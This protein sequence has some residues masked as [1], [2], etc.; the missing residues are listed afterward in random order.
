MNAS[1][2]TQFGN[3]SKRNFNSRRVLFDTNILLDAVDG[4][5][6]GSTEARRALEFCNG[7]GDMGLVT[8]GSL[9]D[10]Y[11][12]LG[13]MYGESTARQAVK[14]MLNLLVVAPV[15]VEECFMAANSSEPDFEDGQIRAVAELNDVAFILTRDE[16]TF[17]N[18]RVRA[19]NCSEYLRI[20]ESERC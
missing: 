19:V 8:P 4:N 10:L 18:S 15:G 2:S 7:G 9:K 20:I 12:I 16:K 1:S 5:R 11:Y 14:H 17:R 3:R 13:R 6:P